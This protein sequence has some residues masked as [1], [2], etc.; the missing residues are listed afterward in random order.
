MRTNLQTKQYIDL[1][2]PELLPVITAQKAKI[3]EG[4]GRVELVYDI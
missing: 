1:H 2:L 4:K 3:T